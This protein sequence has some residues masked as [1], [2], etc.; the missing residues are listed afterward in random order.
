MTNPTSFQLKKS[1]V[2]ITDMANTIAQLQAMV[3]EATQR[4]EAAEAKARMAGQRALSFKVS[5]KGAVSVYGLGRFPLT[6]Y[7][8][9]W[10]RL[11]ERISDLQAF[12]AAN[13]SLLKLS[14]DAED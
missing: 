11:I 2:S 10:E 1:T 14:R 12:I 13:H 8:G 7:L 4:A 3:A 5:P 6:L 9:Q